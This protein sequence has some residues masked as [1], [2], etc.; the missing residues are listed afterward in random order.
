MATLEKVKRKRKFDFQPTL[1]DPN[2]LVIIPT[3]TYGGLRGGTPYCVRL[4]IHE[5]HNEYGQTPGRLTAEVELSASE[6]KA[7]VISLVQTQVPSDMTRLL[8]RGKR[9]RQRRR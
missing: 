3:S 9:A 4:H 5:R 7:L 2:D 8:E 6:V 1:F